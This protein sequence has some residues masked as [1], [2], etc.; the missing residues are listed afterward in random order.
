MVYSDY[1]KLRILLHR[2]RGIKPSC[3][4]RE[5]EA[6]GITVSQIGVWKNCK[7]FERYQ[8]IQQVPGSGRPSK[9]T[10]DIQRLVNA[11]MVED[12]ETTAVQLQKLLSH[13]GFWLSLNT[14]LRARAKLGWTFKGSAYCQ[15]I[16]DTNKVKR[17]EWALENRE[18][19]Q[20]SRVPGC[21]LV[22]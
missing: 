2:N 14:I 18:A 20:S 11:Q 3:I 12:D 7:Q 8:M 10:T 4:V 19:S 16:R 21:C 9:I 13:N 6:E 5:L 15:L 17:L 1:T 22:R